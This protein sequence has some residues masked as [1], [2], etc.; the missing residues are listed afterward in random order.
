MTLSRLPSP[1]RRLFACLALLLPGCASEVSPPTEQPLEPLDQGLWGTV[2]K[3]EGSFF[4]GLA[5]GKVYPIDADIVVVAGR[6]VYQQ[7]GRPDLEG[8]TI[9]SVAQ[10]TAAAGYRIDLAP[11]RYTLFESLEGEPFLPCLE[12]GS[13]DL[14]CAVD[15]ESGVYRQLDFEDRREARF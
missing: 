10:S 13:P 14:F 1:A 5:E 6:V 11:G 8:A 12:P 3:Y 7:T 9:T 4:E 2:I 15:V